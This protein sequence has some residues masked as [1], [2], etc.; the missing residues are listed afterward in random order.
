MQGP[1]RRFTGVAKNTALL[2]SRHPQ[3]YSRISTE[4]KEVESPGLTPV[5]P[6]FACKTTAYAEVAG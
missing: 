6:V 4:P 1:R 2:E 5:A 3:R